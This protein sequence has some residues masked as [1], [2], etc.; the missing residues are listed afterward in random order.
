MN[1][2]QQFAI[3]HPVVDRSDLP[4]IER[5]MVRERAGSYGEFAITVTVEADAE[6][7][8]EHWR[9]VWHVSVSAYWTRDQLVDGRFIRGRPD[10]LK[11]KAM[12]A[13]MVAHMRTLAY[14][15]LGGVGSEQ[16][17]RPL[18]DPVILQYFPETI[19]LRKVLNDDELKLIAAYSTV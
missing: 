10:P 13:A 7:V 17:V 3:E 14:K 6:T 15:A 9:P 4:E 19:H 16:P 8:R 1:R 12:P 11:L 2:Q 5:F 18:M